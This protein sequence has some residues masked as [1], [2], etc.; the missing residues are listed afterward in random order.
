MRSFPPGT[1]SP[2]SSSRQ[3][4]WKRSVAALPGVALVAAGLAVELAAGLA[5][6]LA[7]GLAVELAAGLAVELAAGL[8]VELAAGLAVELAAVPARWRP[9]PLALLRALALGVAFS[10]LD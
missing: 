4:A 8:A 7:A 6:E 9:E 3:P 2:S 10:L 1:M 5:V